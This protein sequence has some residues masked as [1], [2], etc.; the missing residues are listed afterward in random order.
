MSTIQLISELKALPARERARVIRAA[1]PATNPAGRATGKRQKPQARVTWPD[2]TELKRKVY[3]NRRLPNL[4][5]LERE[6]GRY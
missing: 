3:G 2:L 5:L 6:E 4:V 1:M